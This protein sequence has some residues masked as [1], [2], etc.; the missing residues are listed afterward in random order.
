MKEVCV[1]LAPFLE[2]GVWHCFAMPY[3]VLQL[4]PHFQLLSGK[5]SSAPIRLTYFAGY[6][7]A[8]Q[9]RWMMAASEITFEQAG[10]RSQWKMD[11]GG[12]EVWWKRRKMRINDILVDN[13]SLNG[14][15]LFRGLTG[16]QL[17]EV[18]RA[19][20]GFFWLP[21]FAFPAHSKIS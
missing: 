2:I 19:S 3:S 8:E 16:R 10:Q 5:A 14:F 11:F 9:V 7:L 13:I 6:G 18:L 15:D 4:S 21:L 12:K 1:A 20:E 17:K